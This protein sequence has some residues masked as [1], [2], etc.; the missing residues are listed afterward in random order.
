MLAKELERDQ[1]WKALYTY[2]SAYPGSSLHLYFKSNDGS[3]EGLPLIFKGN[4]YRLPRLRIDPQAAAK[5]QRLPEEIKQDFLEAYRKD[6][7]FTLSAACSRYFGPLYKASRE[8]HAYNP[9]L[10]LYFH[11]EEIHPAFKDIY[12]KFYYGHYIRIDQLAEL[13]FGKNIQ[14][15]PATVADEKMAYQP[16][17]SIPLNLILFG[18]P[19][20]GKTYSAIAY[21]VAIIEG[22]PLADIQAEDRN[23][24]KK[25]YEQYKEQEQ[26]EFITFHQSYA[27]EDFVQGLR[28]DVNRNTDT[29]HFKLADG[30]FKRIADRAKANFEAYQQTIARPKLPFET[31]L[32]RLL[33]DSMNRETEEVELPITPAGGQFKSIIIYEVGDIWLKYKRRTL[34]DMVK[35]EER[36]LYLHKIKE[37]YY[38][39]EVRDAINKPYYETIVTALRQFEK[40][41]TYSNDGDHLKNYVLI[42]DEINRAN[43]SRVFGELIT[44]LEEDKRYGRENEIVATLPAGEAF[45]VPSNLYIV[46]TMNTADKSIA[47]L[48]I[49]LRR[50]FEFIGMYPD[51]KAIPD[52]ERILKPM[53]EKIKEKKGAD[54]LIGHSYFIG[55]K[56][57]DEPEI[58][59][60][61]IIP[62]L[63]EYFN[64]RSD[65]VLEV[66]RTTGLEIVEENYQLKV[67]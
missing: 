33:I 31:I 43:I 45:A 32:D 14:T 4:V 22:K 57:G 59:N 20:T 21:T 30:V 63:H 44:L 5:S 19:G 3:Y 11:L 41:L 37:K 51:Y 56:P 50:R 47:L 6:P 66:L 53:N 46:G 2:L 27:Y 58:F 64:N 65:L 28:P 36:L 48:D 42:I 10:D 55:K 8:T 16:K 38:G 9:Y 39:K 60:K 29:L 35:E 62:L 34:R 18:P 61:K 13:Y 15:S 54:F 12:E 40:N 17:P 25:R 67:V 1:L 26:V 49:A 23:Q 7:L 52:F 24:I